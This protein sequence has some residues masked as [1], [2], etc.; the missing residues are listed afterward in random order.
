MQ[1]GA[2]GMEK[3]DRHGPDDPDGT[4]PALHHARRV[5]RWLVMTSGNLSDEPI[6]K[7]NDEALSKL[8]G[9]ADGFLLHDREIHVHC[10]TVLASTT[11]ST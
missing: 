2:R 6:V 11:S 4:R 9:L 5:S 1:G 8:A 10:F 7:D 3:D